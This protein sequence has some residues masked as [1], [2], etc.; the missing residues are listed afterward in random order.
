MELSNRVIRYAKGVS[1]A[2]KVLGSFLLD[3][4]KYEWES[5]LEKLKNCLY[6]DIQTVLKISYDGLDIEEKNLFLD[7]ACFFNRWDKHLVR[8]FSSSIGLRVL[9]DKALITISYGKVEVHDLLQEMGMEIVRQESLNK[10]GEHSR[11]WLDNDVYDVLNK[12]KGT[13][14]IQGR[15]FN[16]SEIREI[17]LNPHAFSEVDYLRLLIVDRSKYK[18]KYN[19]VHGFEELE[20]DFTELRCLCWDFYPSNHCL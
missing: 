11:L 6:Q 4:G 10:L 19:N 18:G 5:T 3:K 8:R 15:R 14:K 17:H 12:N 16:M 20:S 2:L 13:D 1:L 9:I 7:I